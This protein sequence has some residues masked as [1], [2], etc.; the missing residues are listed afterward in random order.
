[1]PHKTGLSIIA[2]E[3]EIYTKFKIKQYGSF[4]MQEVFFSDFPS[5]RF[6]FV[7]DEDI[8]YG[9]ALQATSADGHEKVVQLLSEK[10][11]DIN[12]QGGSYGTALQA[13]SANGHE[14]VVQ[15]LLEKGADIDVQCGRYGTAIQAASKKGHK[16]VVQLLLKKG[17]DI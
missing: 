1:M 14:K 13:A 10:G 7:D 17:A 15:L 5:A 4:E 12:V 11:A 3:T 6:H 9:T 16:V 2:K 8:I